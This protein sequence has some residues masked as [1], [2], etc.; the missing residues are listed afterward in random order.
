MLLSIVFVPI[1]PTLSYPPPPATYILPSSPRCVS[2]SLLFRHGQ[3]SRSSPYYY[4]P[5]TPHEREEEEGV[6]RRAQLY[7]QGEAHQL[8]HAPLLPIERWAS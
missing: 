8:L 3:R 6:C 2:L 1:S 4:A 7:P 5:H